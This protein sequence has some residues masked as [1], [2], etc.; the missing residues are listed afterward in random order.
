MA[1]SPMRTELIAVVEAMY[2][3]PTSLDDHWLGQVA[4][5]IRPVL[6][7]HA[8]GI[9]GGFYVCADP[10]SFAPTTVVSQG[11]PASLRL[12]FPPLFQAL[13]PVFVADSFLCRS[14]FL[15][16]QVRGWNDIPSV[17]DG[18]LRSCG[19]VDTVQINALEPDGRGCWLCSPLPQRA[20]V[21]DGAYVELA[22]LAR[23]FAAA[24]RI[25]R[26]HHD[27]RAQPQPNLDIF[28]LREREV[29]LRALRGYDNKVIAYDLGLA[30]S[31]VRVLMA[32]AATKVGARSRGEL[33]EKTASIVASPGAFPAR[34]WAP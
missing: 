19:A 25:R 22:L 16:T 9:V 27:A 13:S 21:A 29:V 7:V 23:H 33:L 34:A 17:R 10:S 28:T 20:S 2:D 30:H 12:I 18:L 3:D 5:R 26:A 15:G 14:L 11:F 6:D 8:L 4:E 31:T 24:H 32:R 1:A